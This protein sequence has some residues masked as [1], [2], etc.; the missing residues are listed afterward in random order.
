MRE[1]R[2]SI[3]Q[4]VVA[5]SGRRDTLGG[6]ETFLRHLS[7]RT[8]PIRLGTEPGAALPARQYPEQRSLK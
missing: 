7:I 3:T 1:R 6:L 4:I 2:G 8:N 5:R